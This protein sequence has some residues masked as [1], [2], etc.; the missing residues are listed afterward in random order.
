MTYFMHVLVYPCLYALKE[1]TQFDCCIHKNANN[2]NFGIIKLL[3]TFTILFRKRRKKQ[4]ANEA[5]NE[6]MSAPSCVSPV[7]GSLTKEQYINPDNRPNQES[8]NLGLETEEPHIYF[9]PVEDYYVSP[10]PGSSTREQYPTP[11]DRSN[12][13]SVYRWVETEEPHIYFE[14]VE[15]YYM[16]P[17]PGSSTKEQYTTPDDRSNQESVYRGLETEEPHIYFKS[18]EDYDD[19]DIQR[20]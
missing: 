6:G 1:T 20:L 9:E 10:V 3:F 11:D 17:V 5:N 19:V 18:V 13:K 14:P 16:S 12:Q 8:V 15:D 4:A 2:V 7:P